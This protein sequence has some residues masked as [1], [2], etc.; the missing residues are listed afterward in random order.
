MPVGSCRYG[1]H[2]LT[3]A[4]MFLLLSGYDT[5]YSSPMRERWLGS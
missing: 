3:G 5:P 4:G 1:Y 2:S